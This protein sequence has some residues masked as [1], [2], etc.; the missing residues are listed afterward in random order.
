MAKIVWSKLAV[1][2]IEGIH[3]F[4]AKEST[5]YAQ[6]TIENFLT[7]VEVLYKSD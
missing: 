6:K 7:R 1:K 5:F 4:I 2:D 3:D